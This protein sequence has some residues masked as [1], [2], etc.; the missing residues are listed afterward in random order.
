VPQAGGAAAVQGLETVPLLANPGGS[1]ELAE[2]RARF[3]RVIQVRAGHRARGGAFN[4][5]GP[6][7]RHP[8][9]KQELANWI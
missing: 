8:L 4:R 1:Q 5:R 3:F 6:A 9:E 7:P 2:K